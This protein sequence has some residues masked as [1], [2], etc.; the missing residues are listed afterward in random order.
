MWGRRKEAHPVRSGGRMKWVQ[1][2]L[3]AEGGFGY[4][5]A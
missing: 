1:D 3:A 2:N 4:C 5:G